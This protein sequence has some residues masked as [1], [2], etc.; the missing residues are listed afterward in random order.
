MVAFAVYWNRFL[1]LVHSWLRL[2]VVVAQGGFALH[3]HSLMVFDRHHRGDFLA[4]S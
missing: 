3:R 2:R 1:G 4:H